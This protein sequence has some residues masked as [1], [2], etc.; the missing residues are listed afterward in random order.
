MAPAELQTYTTVSSRPAA[1]TA[2]DVM[3]QLRTPVNRERWQSEIVWMR[4]PDVLNP[5]DSVEGLATMLGFLVEGRATTTGLG[6]R[7]YE[8]DVVVG[9]R[10]KIRFDITPSTDGVL[11]KHTLE[12]PLPSGIA[13]RVLSAF[14]R[15]RLRRMQRDSLENLC[16]QAESGEPA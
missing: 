12:A 1:A 5:G 3:S 9:V 10:M 8:E 6:P 14:L 15:R 16:R 13:G 4:G 2:D 7:H 11:V